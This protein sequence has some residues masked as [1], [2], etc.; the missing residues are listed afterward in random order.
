[1]FK[2]VVMYRRVDNE[3][4]LE[5]FFANTHLRLV[6]QLPG[7]LKTEVSRVQ[8]KPGGQ[9]RFHLMVESYFASK[10]EYQRAMLSETGL[11]LIQAFKPW[12]EAKLLVWFY[13][14]AF[15]EAGKGS[16]V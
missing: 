7:L 5:A 11:A 9:S 14:E 6:E 2:F 13:A 8:G 15:E 3:D 10:E 1:M 16:Q 12:D 4:V